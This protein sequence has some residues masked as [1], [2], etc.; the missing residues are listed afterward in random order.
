MPRFPGSSCR[1]S[2]LWPCSSLLTSSQ[3]FTKPE[4][5]LPSSSL[6][7]RFGVGPGQKDRIHGDSPGAMGVGTWWFLLGDLVVS[8]LYVGSTV[9]GAHQYHV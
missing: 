5:G 2:H 1:F 7:G 4:P 8:E 9:H 3:Y 6:L